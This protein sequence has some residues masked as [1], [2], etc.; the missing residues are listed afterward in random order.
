V[1]VL[2]TGAGGFIGQ[3]VCRKLAAEGYQLT[4]VIRPGSRLEAARHNILSVDLCEAALLD[5]MVKDIPDAVVHLAAI[6][7]PSFDGVEAL[8]AAEANRKIDKN[9]FRACNV[10]GVSA[11]YAS[12]A[13]VY[14]VGNGEAK[15]ESSPV[16][17]IG[18]YVA[19]KLEGE[20]IGQKLLSEQGLP[21]TIL[22]I[23][24][25]YGPDQ[26][27]RTVLNLFIERAINGLPLLYHGTGSR[28]QVFTYVEDVANAVLTAVQRRRNGI[29]NIAGGHSISMK[30]LALLVVRCTPGS[31]NL[32]APSGKEDPQEGATVMYTTAKAKAELGWQPQVTLESGIRTWIDARLKETGENRLGI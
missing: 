8:R 14:G 15:S 26:R 20:Q 30:E 3:Y 19:G 6:T 27:V 7:P 11:V 24:A 2:V 29:Y 18:P 25:P 9:V 21:L 23:S 28:Q 12:G 10:W 16:S 1:K 17:P 32:V 31:T 5:S 22:R 13:S 4:R